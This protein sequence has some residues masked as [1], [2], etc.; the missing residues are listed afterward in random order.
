MRHPIKYFIFNKDSDFARGSRYH[1]ELQSPGIGLTEA[2]TGYFYSRLL[3]SREKNMQWHRI[4]VEGDTVSEASVRFWIYASD[5]RTFLWEGKTRDIGEVIEDD[6]ISE[7]E[8]YRMLE[9]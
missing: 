1:A 8:K 9:P 2:G 4:L 3:D 5:R 6:S 7:E